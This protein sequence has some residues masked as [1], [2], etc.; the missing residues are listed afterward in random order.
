M[1]IR[2]NQKVRFFFPSIDELAPR[3]NFVGPCHA[4]IPIW[5]QTRAIVQCHTSHP[6]NLWLKWYSTLLPY[7]M[8]PYACIFIKKGTSSTYSVYVGIFTHSH[9]IQ[10]HPNTTCWKKAN[11][12]H[13]KYLSFKY[14]T[15]LNFWFSTTMRANNS[16]AWT[17]ID[18]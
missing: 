10:T 17:T 13:G 7:S 14:K 6:L 2:Q 9:Y 12:L 11:A 4:V 16:S 8:L 5:T 1:N 18:P 3:L 15:F